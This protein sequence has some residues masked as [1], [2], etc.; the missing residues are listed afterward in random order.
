MPAERRRS[1]IDVVV[2]AALAATLVGWAIAGLIKGRVA[3]PVGVT[4]VAVNVLVG[5]LFLTRRPVRHHASAGEIALAIPSVLMGPAAMLAAPPA[6]GWPLAANV[7]F[8]AAAAAL[9]IS[10]ATLGTSFSVLPALREVVARGPYRLVRHPIYLAELLMVVAAAGVA[11]RSFVGLAVIA[12]TV[13]TLA[14]RIVVEERVLMNDDAYAA[15][16]EQV[17]WRLFPLLW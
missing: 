13:V 9:V 3:T 8:V 10:L 14:L 11:A 12:G 4:L 2:D 16:R 6:Q 5:L 1:L 7:L 17:R 15:Y